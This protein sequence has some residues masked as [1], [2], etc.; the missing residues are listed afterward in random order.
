MEE[1][2]IFEKLNENLYNLDNIENEISMI[3]LA[4]YQK[5]IE[6]LK[7]KKINEI[8]EFFEQKARF[9]NQKTEKYN[10]EI[11]NNIEKY[12]IQIDKLINTYDNLYVN[13]FKIM[14]SAINNQKN[15]I[16]NIVTLTE[17]IQKE[18]LKDEE[19]EKISNTIIACAEKKLNYA[20]IIEECKARI[21][22]CIEDALNNIDEIFKNNI[23]QLQIYDENIINKIKRNFFNI[24]FG[25]SSYK[26]FVDN[27]EIEYLKDIKQ[28]NNAKILDITSTIKGIIKQMEET[29]KQI[30]LKY[31]E[32]MCA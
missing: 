31:K 11:N 1:N 26:K 9:Y 5:S 20:V 25:K 16:A 19:V 2:Q 27:Y 13:V 3:E 6:E 18:D 24:I 17:R 14:E 29:K 21:K 10:Y 23:Y 4:I 15:A 28:K 32:K 30:S 22:W 12:K 7:N 8:R